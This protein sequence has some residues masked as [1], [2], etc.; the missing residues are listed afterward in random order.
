MRAFRIA[1]QIPAIKNALILAV[2]VA[3]IALGERPQNQSQ[4]P[5]AGPQAAKSLAFDVASIKGNILSL[6]GMSLKELIHL[7]YTLPSDLVS[8]GPG[9]VDGTRYDIEAKAAGKASQKERLEMLKTLLADRFQLTF[10]YESKVASTYVLTVGKNSSKLKERRPGDGGE[11][12]GIRDTGSLHYVCRDT[13]MAWFARYLESTVLSR[14]VID[15]TGLSGT[16]DFD[17]SWRPDD[18]QFKGRFAGSKEAQSDLPD[19]FTALKDIGL[20]LETVKSPVQFL[21]IDHAEKPS[22]N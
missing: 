21:R 12:T 15:K 6:Q 8:G 20:R 2:A 7:A 13:S 14:P 1:P 10:H 17:L 11:P 22:E 18:S 3:P 16:Y 5:D 19:L 9:W 4:P